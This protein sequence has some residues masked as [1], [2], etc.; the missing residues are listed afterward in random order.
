MDD[1]IFHWAHFESALR[2][3]I[4]VLVGC[5]VIC[6]A[7][8]L[9]SY[10]IH[11]FEVSA[12]VRLAVATFGVAVLGGLIGFSGGNAREGVVGDLMPAILSFLAVAA[13]Y[14]LGVAKTPPRDEMYP[15]VI[16][17]VLVLFFS[18]ALGASNRGGYEKGE[19]RRQ[20]CLSVF[21]NAEVL[22][23]IQP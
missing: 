6:S 1:L 13:A 15:I 8:I 5:F 21:T 14:L 11:R 19:S 2:V 17:F 10:R 7:V 22:A 3:S 20:V 23:V 12:F 18:Y 16:S 4:S 9:L